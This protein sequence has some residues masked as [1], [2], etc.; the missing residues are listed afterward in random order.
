VLLG[1]WPILVL[2]LLSI[3]CGFA[4]S[5]GP[6]PISYT[7]FGEAFVLVFFGVAAVSG[8]YWLATGAI[9][10]SPVVAGVAMGLFA[11]AVLLVNNHRDRDEDGRAG[12]RTLSIAIGGNATCWLYAA[13]MLLPFVLVL[14]LARLLM[15]THIWIALV[16]APLALVTIARFVRERPGPGFNQILAQTAQTQA[17]YAALLCL[18]VIV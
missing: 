17:A 4:Y 15:G 5:G 18:G 13:L 2:G 12:R 11:A 16:A 6:W 3:A 8:V 14:P 10:P 9:G 1:G 7:P